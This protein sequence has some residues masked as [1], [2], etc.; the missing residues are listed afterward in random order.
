MV[1]YLLPHARYAYSQVLGVDGLSEHVRHLAKLILV[2]P[3]A[4]ITTRDIARRWREWRV[5]PEYQQQSTLKILE[6]SGWIIGLDRKNGEKICSKYEVNA[7]LRVLYK[8]KAEV[9]ASKRAQAKAMLS[10]ISG[11]NDNAG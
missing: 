1:S 6:D 4:I 10:Q 2:H 11:G 7:R 9:E 5:L 3:D 8:D